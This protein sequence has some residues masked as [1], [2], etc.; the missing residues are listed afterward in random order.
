MTKNMKR[1]R[2]FAVLLF[3]LVLVFVAAEV[4]AV[5]TAKSRHDYRV[6]KDTADEIMVELSLISSSLSSGNRTLYDNSLERY[7]NT[8]ADFSKNDYA[9]KDQQALIDSLAKYRDTLIEGQDSIVDLLELSAEISNIE[10]SLID[11]DETTLDVT[12]FYQIQQTFMNLREVV[13][14][15]KESE[16]GEI[17]NR[18]D[19][20]AERI[21]SLSASAAVCVSI[22]PKDS[23]ESKANQLQELKQKYRE[24]FESLGKS[25]SAKYDPSSLIVQLKQI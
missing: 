13:A 16:F 11:I 2:N 1:R 25:L 18:L 23:F 4:F 9:K 19:E 3:V 20:Y 6:T 24:D 21:A 17:A 8:L 10:S 5:F 14:K 22:C 15:M 7:K 12:N